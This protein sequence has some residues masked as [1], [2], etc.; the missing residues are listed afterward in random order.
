MAA[1]TVAAPFAPLLGSDHFQA[2]VQCICLGSGRFLRT[3][4]VPALLEIN[5]RCVIAQ[6]RGTSF[7][8]RITASPTAE[9]EVD[10]VPP[11]GDT[12][13][14]SIPVAGVGSLGEDEGRE[15][16]LALP[17]RLPNLRFIG[18]G[19]TEGA[20]KEGEWHM[21]LLAALLAACEQAGIAHMSVINTDNVP[22]N[23]DLLRSI[24]STCSER[25]SEQ[26]LAAF[27]AF[28]NTMVDCIT[29][30]REGDTVVPRA[31][32]LPAKAL[33]IE[34][35][36]R[37]LPAALMDVPGV[38]LRHSAGLIEKDHAMKLRIANGTHTAAAHIMALSGL[39]DTSQIAA[40]PSITRFLQK[41][42]ESDIAPGCVADFAIPRPE[43]DAVWGEWSR[44]MTSP[45]FGL[46]TF[47]ITQNA[48]AKLG[49]RLVPSLNAALRARRLPSA[50]MALSVAALLRFITP[51]QP[52]PRPGVGAA[53]MDAA[54]PPSTAVLE[55][56]PGLTVDFGSGAYEFVLSAGAERLAHA[57]H[58]QRRA[59]QLQQRQQAQ[60]AAALDSAATALDAVLRCLEEQ[61]LDMASPL[62]RPAAQRVCAVYTRLVQGS[63]ALELLEELVGD[64]GGG[65][66]GGA[67][68]VYLGAGEVGEVA[69]AEVERV[70]VIDLHTH[71]LPPSHA[72]LMLWGID[73][74]LTYHYLVAEYFMTAAPPAPDPD[75]FHALP[76]RQQAEL[77]WKGLFLDRSP[78]SEAARGVLTTLQLLGLE[79][80]ARARDLEAI[81]AFFAAADPDDYTERV[82]HQAGVRYCVMTNVPFD[83][84]EVEHWRPLARPYSG[85][86]RSALRVDPLLKGD[87]A[88]VLAAVRGEGFEGTLEGVR[89]CLRGW[90]K[91]MQPEYLMASTPHDF[92]V[93]EEDIAAANT[94]G[95]DGSG[96]GAIKG[97][98]LLFRVLLPLAEE[99]NLPLALKLG[100]HR[101]V[102]PKLRGGGDGVVTGQSQALRLLLTHFPRVKFLGT[103]LARSEQHEAVVLANKFGNFHLYGCWWYCNNPSMIAEITTMRLEMLGTAFTAQHSDARV[104]D[105][106]L[107]KWTHS[108][109]VI[110]DVLAAQYEK[111]IAAGWRVTREEVRRDVWRLFGGAYE[112]FIAKDLLV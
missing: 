64:A 102:N 1:P 108:R 23:G 69:R 3:V 20:L 15:A 87:V 58:E 14:R 79:A 12:S 99:L 77:V 73:D 52:A 74:M 22:A 70:E 36:R 75:A 44:R 18:V 106:L 54:R 82:F 31:E 83:A 94:G 51:S 86:F 19:L 26:Y 4:L 111:M 37:V 60:P 46:S 92:R 93:R 30:H 91:T 16:F 63:S 103:F 104:L 89:E 32:P 38:V 43:L 45:A 33:V 27:V 84:A 71:L 41:L 65:E 101:G 47:F 24:V 67:G 61:G 29:S 105:Q 17:K 85:R 28:H 68:G 49:L 10:T 90:A 35:L 100:A 9:Y 107:Y 11:T 56:T 2:D 88:G 34:D 62:A 5:V 25:P 39:A 78:L 97:T 40:N 109:A 21:K 96:K 112:E 80:E 8:E 59:Q 48:Y 7:V 66:G 53:L 76:K 81:R 6:P 110:G 42:Y 50:Y 95:G 72:P 57:C 13:T 55:Y 98:D